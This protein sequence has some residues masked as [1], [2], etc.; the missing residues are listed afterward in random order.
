MSLS[1]VRCFLWTAIL[2]SSFQYQGP[3]GNYASIASYFANSG[4]PGPSL[5]ACLIREGGRVRI[6]NLEP[7]QS[8]DVH[9]PRFTVNGTIYKGYSFSYNPC[10]P[11]KLGPRKSGCR[12]DV[13]ICRWVPNPKI[14]Q[15]IGN[16]KGATC[17]MESETKTPIVVYKVHSPSSPFWNRT[18][19]VRLKCDEGTKDH[20]TFEILDEDNMIFQLS[21]FWDDCPLKQGTLEPAE[22]L[23]HPAVT[24]IVVGA[25]AGVGIFFIVLFLVWRYVKNQNQDN[26]NNGEGHDNDEGRP[27]LGNGGG[28]GAHHP[29]IFHNLFEEWNTANQ[30]RPRPIGSSYTRADANVIRVVRA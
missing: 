25:V 19:T 11:F 14:Y 29:N 13:A 15:I 1:W 28:A 27:I 21:Y 23:N 26:N 7:L 3:D 18:S 20:A 30:A 17:E 10:S 9:R 6:Y 5:C 16:Q 24:T 4:K 22:P 12:N 2:H 8:T